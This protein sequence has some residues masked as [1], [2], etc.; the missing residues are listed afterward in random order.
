MNRFRRILFSQNLVPSILLAS[1]LM[2][3]SLMIGCKSEGGDEGVIV[4]TLPP[5]IPDGVYAVG[6][7][8]QGETI[9]A[10][11][12]CASGQKR[13]ALTGQSSSDDM[14]QLIRFGEFVV[15]KLLVTIEGSRITRT[16]TRTD[17]VATVYPDANTLF[18]NGYAECKA[19]WEGSI[20]VNQES[21]FQETG[22]YTIT[23]E[24]SGCGLEVHNYAATGGS[25]GNGAWIPNTATAYTGVFVSTTH[26]AAQDPWTVSVVDSH[27][28]LTMPNDIAGQQTGYACSDDTDPDR[29]VYQRWAKQ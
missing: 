6:D 9:P 23:W 15:D 20:A 5:A 17:A 21:T 2:L 4:T 27:Y 12:L 14:K 24:P 26:T 7:F 25:I 29:V 10:R 1:V 8:P 18:P 22:T 3:S 13:P 11:T 19:I 16:W 28:R